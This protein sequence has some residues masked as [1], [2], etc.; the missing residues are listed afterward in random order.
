VAERK[1]EKERERKRERERE[2]E[3]ALVHACSPSIKWV[4]GMKF[5]SRENLRIDSGELSHLSDLYFL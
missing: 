4:T 3:H 5:S 1:R 2:R